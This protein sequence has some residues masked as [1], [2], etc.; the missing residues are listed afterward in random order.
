VYYPVVTQNV[1]PVA[2]GTALELTVK[3]GGIAVEDFDE[4]LLN[5]HCIVGRVGTRH[6]L[7]TGRADYFGGEALAVEFQTLALAAVADDSGSVHHG[8]GLA[9]GVGAKQ[10]R[11]STVGSIA[12]RGTSVYVAV[13]AATAAATATATAA[14]AAAAAVT[15][16]VSAYASASTGR[17]A[18][19]CNS[20]GGGVMGEDN[21]LADTS[22]LSI[23]H[24]QKEQQWREQWREEC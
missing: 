20:A 11:A 9:L 16:L 21:T 15:F 18:P 17:T 1:L 4:C 6:A 10:Q 23:Y 19:G 22:Q 14:A 13:T 2:A 8:G 5:A 3:C 24:L 7:A 12:D